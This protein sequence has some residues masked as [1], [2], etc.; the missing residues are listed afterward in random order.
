MY[1]CFICTVINLL[2]LFYLLYLMRVWSVVI[3]QLSYYVLKRMGVIYHNLLDVKI[4]PLVS[5][6]FFVRFCL[7]IPALSISFGEKWR[8]VCY[9]VLI[10][11]LPKLILTSIATIR[12]T[13][14][15]TPSISGVSLR[16]DFTTTILIL[17]NRSL[18]S[19]TSDKFEHTPL[20]LS[21]TERMAHSSI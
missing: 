4:T 1:D 5:E 15:S 21:Q 7:S 12:S 13:P 16:L 3:Y 17:W 18:L 6:P 8:E 19:I 20:H 11:V 10:E 2:L 14:S 9:I